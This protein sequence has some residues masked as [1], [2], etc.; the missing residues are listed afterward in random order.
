MTTPTNDPNI[1]TPE[2]MFKPRTIDSRV[3]RAKPSRDGI[4]HAELTES[5][6]LG[7]RLTSLETTLISSG[8]N[9]LEV[10]EASMAEVKRLQEDYTR[11]LNTLSNIRKRV[12][13]DLS[14]LR[15]V[16]AASKKSKG[17]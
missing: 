6:A 17:S 10:A 4:L 2:S 16:A 12:A 5:A 3:L 8:L 1:G 15:K 7:R 11:A 13:S 14:E 9:N